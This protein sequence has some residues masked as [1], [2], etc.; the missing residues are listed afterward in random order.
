M[1]VGNIA[2]PRSHMYNYLRK[3]SCI[4]QL[5]QKGCFKSWIEGNMPGASEKKQK[6]DSHQAWFRY[7]GHKEN[8]LNDYE[9]TG[10]LR[11][12][13]WNIRMDVVEGWIEAQDEEENG[14]VPVCCDASRFHQECRSKSLW[15]GAGPLCWGKKG[16]PF[17]AAHMSAYGCREEGRGKG[18]GANSDLHK[19][20]TKTSS[21]LLPSKKQKRFVNKYPVL[22]CPRLQ[23]PKRN[24][25]CSQ[26]HLSN[27]NQIILFSIPVRQPSVYN[28][29]AQIVGDFKFGHEK[30][31]NAVWRPRFTFYRHAGRRREEIRWASV[32]GM[33]S[34]G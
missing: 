16:S 15:W 34:E 10:S 17:R 26:Q 8:A 7:E 18:E 29:L 24:A 23:L 6:R 32:K 11:A 19:S 21:V 28:G 31:S 13:W 25:R 33:G 27:P 2:F 1:F 3:F 4:L 22:L 14:F 30:Q 9:L 20:Q 12:E 5:K